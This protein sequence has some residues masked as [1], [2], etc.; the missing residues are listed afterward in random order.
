MKENNYKE[1]KIVL[2]GN[3]NVGKTSILN[4]LVKGNLRIG[5]WPGVTVEKKEGHVFFNGYQITFID[6]PGLYTLEEI[7]SEDEKIAFDFIVSRDYDLILNII[8]TPRIERDLYLTCQLLDIEKP[9]ILVLNMIDEAE[10]YGME[11]NVERLSELLNVK[12]FK[13][14]GRTGEGIKEILPAIIEVYEKNTK[15]ITINYPKEIENKIKEKNTFKWLK[16]QEIIKENPELYKIIKEKQLRFSKGLTKEVIHKKILHKKTLTETL[17]SLFL[18]PLLGNFFFILIMYL[19]FKISFDFS[20]PLIDWMDNFLQNFL[21]PLITKYLKNIGAPHFLVSFIVGALIGGVGMVLSFIPLV[22][23]MYFLLT[24]LETSGYLPR[25]AFLMDRFTHRIGLHGQSVIPLILGLG[26]NVPAVIAT[27][28]FQDIKDKLLVISMIPF[29]SCPARLIIFSFIA[30][31]FFKN[32]ALIIFILYLI[33]IVFSILTSLILRKTLLKKKLSHF[34]MDLPPYRI[35]SLKIV[36]NITKAYLKDF[37]YK[38][39]TIIF[40]VSM[41]M[42][43]LLNLPFG[44]KNIENS[45]A[46]KIGKTLSYIFEPIGLEDWRITT[47]LLSGFL[48][49]EAIISNWGVI[50]TKEGE[51]TFEISKN[52][53]YTGLKDKIKELLTPKQALSFLLFVLIY[54]SC[55]A[56]VVVMAKEGNWK[57]A[58]GFWLYSFIL[59]WLISFINFNLF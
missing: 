31:I 40:M 41:V 29:I 26:C 30:F 2:V 52:S 38:A 35:P 19:F 34:V 6:L 4:H 42:W 15:P 44:E 47:S 3:P 58:L 51:N 22:F 36:F 17:D 32:P 23:T 16:L 48:A 5:N 9:L 57:F 8:E 55:L 46:G 28:T 43:L 45:I 10:S 11:V 18:H 21:G 49:R 54:N 24:I 37:V 1:I 27:R 59:A 50:M 56:T 14:N 25:V 39:G 12:V 20:S 7:V 13:T 33:G 53:K